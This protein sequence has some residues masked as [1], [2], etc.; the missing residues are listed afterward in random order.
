MIE[1]IF[2]VRF[3]DQN[4]Y[5][6]ITEDVYGRGGNRYK[7]FPTVEDA[8][9]SVMGI[10]A[11]VFVVEDPYDYANNHGFWKAP[12]RLQPSRNRR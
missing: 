10:D 7:T 11:P 3:P 8:R 6:V 1:K 12:T 9:A 4:G 5:S 2:I